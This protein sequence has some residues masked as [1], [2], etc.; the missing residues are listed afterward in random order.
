MKKICILLT[1][2]C[3]SLHS[4]AQIAVDPKGT[5]ILVDSSKWK[6]S[7][8]NIYN[9]NSGNIGIGTAAPTAQ[10]HT[11]GS[12]RFQ[13]IGTNTTNTKLLTT[14]D[15][16]N[17]TTRLFSNLL[18]GNAVTSLNGLTNSAQT[19]TT[20]ATGTDFNIV[21]SG[22]VHSLNIPSASATSRGALA[23]AD[24]I[25]FNN[26]TG[27]VTA[28]TPAAVTTAA[29]TATINNTMA[30]WNA[31]QLQGK[32]IATTAPA[33]GQV[34]TYNTA[35]TKWEPAAIPTVTTTVSN[36]NTAP[37]SLSTTVN[38]I[39]GAIVPIINAV[40]NTSA[41]NTLKTTVNGIA[42]A[43]VNIIN[44][45]TLTQNG[46]NQL[47][48]TVNGVAATALTANITGDVTGNMGAAV[49]SKINGSPLGTITGA[50]NGQVLTW[51][52]SAWVPAAVST[53]TTVSNTN[54]A[55]N[56]LS[57]TVN[58]ITGAAVAIVNSVSNNSNN[59][60]LTTTV[61]G[62]T[63][64][65]VPIVNSIANTSSANTLTTSVNGVTGAS[66]PIVNSIGN[67]SSGNS[68]TTT[69]NGITGTAVPIINTISNNMSGGNLTTTVNG[70]T[71]AP[72]NLAG[73]LPATT[74]SLALSG[75]TLTSTVNGVSA[76]SNAVS[77]V[78]N[79]SSVNNLTTTVNGVTATTVPII[80]SISNTSSANT[81][82]TTVNGVT[83]TAVPMINSISNSLAGNNLTTTVNG[84]ASTAI[85]LAGIIPATTNTIGL[86]GNTI[87]ST[88]DG[89]SDTTL[90]V[91]SV[92]N[93][94]YFNTLFTTVNGI[95]GAGVNIINSNAL[96]LSN[97]ALTSTVNGISSSPAVNILASASN[98]LTATNGNVQ[99]GGALTQATTISTSA[100]NTL[101][102]AGLQ[103]GLSTDSILVA[104]SGTGTIKK[105]AAVSFPQVL[106]DARRTTTYTP[107]A[108]FTTIVYNSTNINIGT[109]YSTTTGA[110]TAPATGLYEIIV[111][112]GYTFSGSNAQEQV[113]N[114][115]I[116][117]SV[118]DMEKYVSGY[119]SGSN[120]ISTVSGNT[121]IS[122]TSGQTVTISCGAEI[123]TATP[124]VG[125]GQHVLKIIR[126]Q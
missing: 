125:T 106:V 29:T 118:V 126:L 22:T 11:T 85:S 114:Q 40:S 28:S 6:I 101:S 77:T 27:S 73:L 7:G 71:S 124:L 100:T 89:I 50:S 112:N 119:R 105:I 113:A 17:L 62:I 34:L 19:F 13:G 35:T 67:A 21:S 39:T 104:S 86:S 90:S 69:V 103:T 8:N 122:I 16:G 84:V 91:S 9:K 97:G 23:A 83:G 33:N 20:G 49:V 70:I 116:V 75:N 4:I 48:S 1:L 99:L 123:G 80:N 81:L 115:I 93:T 56:S 31:N 55:P 32:D 120:I 66:A 26:K 87:T 107:S 95:T 18:A 65:S 76:T 58:G 14:D 42:G 108:T 38:G 37:N 52:G 2:F 12:V 3:V 109:S 46:T 68:L 60:T 51:N 121:I 63:G 94:S 72:L 79:T 47:V 44:T 5:K 82:T 25:T 88:V 54:N 74:N 53:T 111:N 45:N 96:A 59:N 30:Y 24:W 102:L 36:T 92:T 15:L 57:T 98:G 110:F 64:T 43:T 78:A 10:L 117:N 61:N 41:A